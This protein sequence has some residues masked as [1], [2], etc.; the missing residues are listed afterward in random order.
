MVGNIA[1]AHKSITPQSAETRTLL[2]TE[3]YS[4][5][6][7]TQEQNKD[8]FRTIIK[9]SHS[10]QTFSKSMHLY[11]ETRFHSIVFIM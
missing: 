4:I 3:L 9:V 11:F 8:I 7:E 10:H 6:F 1:K 5:C 2:D